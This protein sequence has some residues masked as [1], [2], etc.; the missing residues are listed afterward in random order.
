M[1][2]AYLCILIAIFLPYVWTVIAKRSGAHY[3]NHA[4]REWLSQQDNPRVHRANA[5]QLNAFEATPAFVAGVL[6]AQLAQV[7]STCIASLS[8]TFIVARILHG[9]F[10]VADKD[11][12]R[13][14][15][16]FIGFICILALVIQ[17]AIKVVG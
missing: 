3:D 4:P 12:L 10:Y 11:K 2:I 8:V 7:S 17:A 15:V 9:V 5:A 6:M 16:W 1:T 14:L 13:S